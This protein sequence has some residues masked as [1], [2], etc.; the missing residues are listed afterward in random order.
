MPCRPTALGNSAVQARPRHVTALAPSRARLLRGSDGHR[1][2]TLVLSAGHRNTI[3][4]YLRGTLVTRN[5]IMWTTL[6]ECAADTTLTVIGAALSSAGRTI[7]G[8]QMKL[9]RV[10]GRRIVLARTADGYTAFDDG[11][12]HRG[13]SLAGGV[14]I[15]GTVQC[16]WHGSQFDVST[17]A[18]SCGPAKKRIHVYELRESQ[19]G[20]LL[21]LHPPK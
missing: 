13:G 1:Q 10:N 16:L 3:T 6:R 18:V 19:D 5:L 11:C 20:D 17:G 9:L 14:L 15:G 7:R 21:L 12:T 8:N 4:P 2:L